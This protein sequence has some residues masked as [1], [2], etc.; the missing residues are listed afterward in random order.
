MMTR[1]KLNSRA[2]RRCQSLDDDSPAHRVAVLCQE[3]GTRIIDC[4]VHA[5]GGISA[6]LA[7]AEICLA[8]LGRVDVVPGRADLGGGPAV[9]VRT[10]HP[11]AACMASQYAGWQIAGEKFFAMGSGPMRAVRG[12]EAIYD[13]IGL[14]EQADHV[15]GVLES[16]KLPAAAVCEH[17]ASECGVT[18]EQLTLLVAPTR[19]IAGGIQ[20]VARSV[21]T[22]LHKLHTL[23]FD[24]TR[25]Q[26]GFG[27]APL[28]PTAA[29]D[30][31]AIGRTNDA[32]LYGAEVTLWVR[33]DEES[34]A[35]LG[36]HVPSSASR[37]YGRPFA[38]VFADYDHDFYRIDPLLFS[39]AVVTFIHLDSGKSFTFGR[40]APDV[41]RESFQ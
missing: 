6:G 29:D 37:D 27:T 36:P 16:S 12:R 10:D 31:T 22:A 34:L 21:E 38:R 41:L 2:V 33:G 14:R 32:V 3:G 17:V 4:G 19:S 9:T 1:M 13:D 23:G 24:L 15:V 8:D 28:P 30:L 25:V 11:I 40:L 39:P 5:P 18:A 20:V 7:L 26:S 35:R